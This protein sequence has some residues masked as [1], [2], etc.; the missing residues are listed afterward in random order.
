MQEKHSTPE[1][2]VERLL[3][4][5]TALLR[6]PEVRAQ[7]G[8]A[9]DH[10]YRDSETGKPRTTCLPPQEFIHRFSGSARSSSP[11]TTRLPTLPHTHGR[12][13]TLARLPLPPVPH[14]GAPP[15]KPKPS[16]FPAEPPANSLSAHASQLRSTQ[17]FSARLRVKPSHSWGFLYQY[18][19]S[20][21]R[22]AQP[23]RS[24]YQR[25]FKQ[26]LRLDLV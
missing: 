4:G 3:T 13:R 24:R 15:S 5:G 14:P 11:A 22:A 17:G 16:G 1:A 23:I 6:T 21:S 19:L 8:A 7:T 2:G 18:Q 10:H 26:L 9:D 12:R 25:D 20:V